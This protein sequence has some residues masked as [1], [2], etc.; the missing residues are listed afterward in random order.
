MVT[1]LAHFKIPLIFGLHIHDFQSLSLK[2]DKKIL[3]RHNT[4]PYNGENEAWYE[5]FILAT[6][7]F[8][9]SSHLSHWPSQ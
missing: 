8:N 2:F 7:M 6:V 1:I 4:G 3:L 9:H 5:V